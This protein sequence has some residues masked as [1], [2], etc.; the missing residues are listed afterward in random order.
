MVIKSD[1]NKES[2]IETI[3]K[4]ELLIVTRTELENKKYQLER[5]LKNMEKILDTNRDEILKTCIHK[6]N[7]SSVYTGPYEKPDLICSKCQSVLSRW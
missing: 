1:T 3:S 5:E 2:D 7:R 6:W 4:V